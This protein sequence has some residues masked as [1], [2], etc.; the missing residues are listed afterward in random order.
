MAQPPRP[1]PRPRSCRGQLALMNELIYGRRCPITI[2]TPNYL[3]YTNGFSKLSLLR[4]PAVL[5]VVG[6]I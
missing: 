4:N 2:S 6:L 5:L 1:A 3:I